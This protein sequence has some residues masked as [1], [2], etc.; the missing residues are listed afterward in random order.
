MCK[1]Q[2]W[3]SICFLEKDVL[4]MV[5]DTLWYQ[6]YE[7]SVFFPEKQEASVESGGKCH[8]N[9]FLDRKRWQNHLQCNRQ[10]TNLEPLALSAG[11]FICFSSSTPP[12]FLVWLHEIFNF[13][14]K[15]SGK[16]VF[17]WLMFYLFENL[18][19]EFLSDKNRLSFLLI[20]VL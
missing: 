7:K 19:G 14:Q 1:Y 3:T 12:C 20:R 13:T 8:S 18:S 15:L 5:K 2:K 17:G 6:L 11:L 10:N 4:N 9:F 16:C